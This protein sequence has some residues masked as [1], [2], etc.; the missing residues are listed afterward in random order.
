[1]GNPGLYLG[2]DPGGGGAHGVAAIDGNQATCGAVATAEDAINWFI[3][4]CAS[5][6]P[7]AFGIDTLTLWST[8]PA[9]WRP[10][11]RALRAAYPAAAASVTAPNSLYG[12]MPING[13]AVAL[14][15]RN[16]FKM[17]KVTETHPKVLYFSLAHAEYDF[18]QHRDRM[19]AWF[20]NLANLQVC[21]VATEHAWD[22][23]LSAFAAR[24]W[25]TGQW[26]I[27]LHHL[28]NDD[29]ERLIF[30]PNLES[31]YAWP[32]DI[33][34][35]PQQQEQKRVRT[36]PKQSGR[37]K[38]AVE[39]LERAGHHGVA[40]QIAEYRNA[41]NERA[42]WDAWLKSNFPALWSLVEE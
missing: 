16:N 21:E 18:T 32:E 11:D 4:H 15:L 34:R 9:G 6:E 31:H 22:A 33:K 40:Q 38:I 2:Y 1:M 3:E 36:T 13:V 12:A 25:N 41:R 5:C 29:G 17:L 37:W 23:L 14:A 10:A 20:F 35:A 42:G 26:E 24:Q 30:P 28:P 27:D 7:S 19:V 39:R 8:G